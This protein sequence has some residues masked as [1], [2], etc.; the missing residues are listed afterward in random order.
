MTPTIL[1]KKRFCDFYDIRKPSPTGEIPQSVVR[2]EIFNGSISDLSPLRELPN[3]QYLR[4][5]KS[6]V[7]DLSPLSNLPN[8]SSLALRAIPELT[9]LTP[10]NGLPKLKR[11]SF[12]NEDKQTIS[13]E[14]FD[15]LKKA[16]P[17][18]DI[19]FT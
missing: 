1:P 9:D 8:L 19:I 16:L 10:L 17:D 5:E 18:I 11:L 6:L 4:I 2:L 14:Q 7:N 3:L 15:F 12:Y 13:A